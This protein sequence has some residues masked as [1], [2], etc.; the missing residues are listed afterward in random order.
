MCY[1]YGWGVV[2]EMSVS[3]EKIRHH[4]VGHCDCCGGYRALKYQDQEIGDLCVECAN[5]SAIADI[6]LNFGGYHLRRPQSCRCC[7]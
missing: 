7:H 1:F 5:H 2:G 3:I 6:E 4:L